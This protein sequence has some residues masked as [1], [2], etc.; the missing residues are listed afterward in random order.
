[1]GRG[2]S[3]LKPSLDPK[4]SN[5]KNK[6]VKIHTLRSIHTEIWLLKEPPFHWPNI[7]VLMIGL[8]IERERY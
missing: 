6:V 7:C 4:N 1:M 2:E 5:K 8:F 3:S